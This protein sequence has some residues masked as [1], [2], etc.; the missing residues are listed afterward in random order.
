MKGC[1]I[2]LGRG[3]QVRRIFRNAF[4]GFRLIVKECPKGRETIAELRFI[5][6]DSFEPGDRAAHCYMICP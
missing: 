1:A 4:A 3:G 6:S 2:A 5:E